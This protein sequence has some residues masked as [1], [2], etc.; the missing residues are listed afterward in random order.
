MLFRTNHRNTKYHIILVRSYLENMP[1]ITSVH[2]LQKLCRPSQRGAPLAY[3]GM[4]IL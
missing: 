1:L 4:T 2:V 3:K